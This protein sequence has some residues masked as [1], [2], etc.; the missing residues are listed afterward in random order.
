[1][2]GNDWSAFDV[3]GLR[4]GASLNDVRNAWRVKAK[5]LHP[6]FGGDAVLFDVALKAYE[7]LMNALSDA[8]HSSESA[9]QSQP[10][11]PAPTTQ[12]PSEPD[13]QTRQ[14][15][16]ERV[17]AFLAEQDALRAGWTYNSYVTPFQI[18]LTF[19]ASTA[20]A[21][22]SLWL[23]VSGILAH[24]FHIQGNREL[25]FGSSYSGV[26][27][28]AGMGHLKG[29]AAMTIALSLIF[30]SLWIFRLRKAHFYL[31]EKVLYGSALTAMLFGGEYLVH[32]WITLWFALGA[33]GY[34]YIIKKLNVD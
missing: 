12:T 10:T 29:M 34:F 19:L 13:E 28:F 4:E 30:G 9:G 1:M 11:P 25:L 6:D 26:P 17:A 24:I 5:V 18:I 16:A 14:E 2:R 23:R 31:P 32:G 20:L 3:L 8:P 15:Y 21:A 22:L 27:S 7:E 33:A